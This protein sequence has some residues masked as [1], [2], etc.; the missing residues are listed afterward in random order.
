MSLAIQLSLWLICAA[1]LY[2]LISIAINKH[3]ICHDD[4]ICSIVRIQT[5]IILKPIV[6]QGEFSWLVTR[7]YLA[8][9][10]A[11]SGKWIPTLWMD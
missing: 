5:R 7:K 9:Y 2:I 11:Q 10:D 1:L 4:Y 6:I 3:H 8:N